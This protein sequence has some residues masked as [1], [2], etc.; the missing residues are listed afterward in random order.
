MAR[1]E[2]AVV[3]C[4]GHTQTASMQCLDI[5]NPR[6]LTGAP[7]LAGR[8]NATD[9]GACKP[10][11]KDTPLYDANKV[12]RHGSHGARTHHCLQ[13]TH[14]HAVSGQVGTD[15]Q[16]DRALCEPWATASV[17]AP[18]TD[19]VCTVWSHRWRV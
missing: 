6:C 15:R 11:V 5:V 17:H 19:G 4:S 7:G 9:G 12:G 14:F 18:L 10:I 16:G 3:R 13:C 2:M 1:S 8:P